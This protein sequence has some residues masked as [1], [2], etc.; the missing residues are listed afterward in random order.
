MVKNKYGVEVE[1]NVIPALLRNINFG[2]NDQRFERSVGRALPTHLHCIFTMAYT[3]SPTVELGFAL[4]HHN[5]GL[6]D[7]YHTGVHIESHFNG[8][9]LKQSCVHSLPNMY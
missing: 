6:P 4:S 1:K 7:E 2:S 8:L 5:R 9:L 3:L